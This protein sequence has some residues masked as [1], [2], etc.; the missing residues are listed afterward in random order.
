MFSEIFS[1]LGIDRPFKIAAFPVVDL[2]N[3]KSS[4]S[5]DYLITT[6]RDF[7]GLRCTP[8][9]RLIASV[10]NFARTLPISDAADA[11]LF[12]VSMTQNLSIVGGE[13]YPLIILARDIHEPL[14]DEFADVTCDSVLT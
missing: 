12:C 5:A 6:R 1:A 3:E 4:D 14:Q 13:N 11:I 10:R 7:A 2:L 8:V 9:W